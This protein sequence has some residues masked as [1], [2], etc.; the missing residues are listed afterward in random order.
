MLGQHYGLF[1]GCQSSDDS[2]LAERIDE[3]IAR[4]DGE[5]N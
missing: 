2:D 4:V 3:A 1:N 5:S